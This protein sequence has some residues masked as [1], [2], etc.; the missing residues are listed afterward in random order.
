MRTFDRCHDGELLLK[1]RLAEFGFLETTR[2]KRKWFMFLVDVRK[3]LLVT[4][5]LCNDAGPLRIA[6]IDADAQTLHINA[7]SKDGAMK[8]GLLARI[9]GRGVLVLPANGGEMYSVNRTFRALSDIRINTLEHDVKIRNKSLKICDRRALPLLFT[10][11]DLQLTTDSQ[12]L[13]NCKTVK[14]GWIVS[15]AHGRDDTTAPSSLS[16]ICCI[17]RGL[18]PNFIQH[19]SQCG[20]G[21][22]TVN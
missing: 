10:E 15:D 18:T 3:G 1:R 7:M 12:A 6:S 4:R 8:Y 16:H 17:W 9:E 13:C 19:R 11:K 2:M 20:S 5:Y 21:L 14:L 22:Y